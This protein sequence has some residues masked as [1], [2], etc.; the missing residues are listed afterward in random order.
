M[1]ALDGFFG[2]DAPVW[3]RLAIAL[4]IGLVVGL[5]R[6]WKTRDQHGGQRLAGLRTF[7]L[8]ALCGGVLA[9]LSLPDRFIVLAAGALA[10]GALIVGGYLI[11]ARQQ[12]DF[13]MTTELVM[14]TTFGLGAVAVLGAPFEAIAAGVV[15]GAGLGDS[16]RAAL[17]TRGY[18]EMVRLALTLGARAETLAGL[19][20]FGDLVLTCTSDQSRNFRYGRSLVNGQAFDPH[21]TVEGIATARAVV[22]LA[23]ERGV[24]LPVT[25]MVDALAS[26]RVTLETAIAQLMSRPLKQE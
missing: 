25:Q 2:S 3:H 15:L 24:D 20:G 14:L 4:G 7:A 8:T 26:G 21:L 17:M 18:A 6:G 16:A 23:A 22:R 9:A 19:S 1:A 13:G 10:V 12:N 11:S 5:E